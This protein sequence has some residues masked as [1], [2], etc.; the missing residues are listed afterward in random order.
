MSR[1]LSES[2]KRS[3]LLVLSAL[4]GTW[5]GVEDLLFLGEWCKL[6]DRKHVWGKRKYETVS[7]H[8]DD[9]GLLKKDYNYL[10]SLHHKLLSVLTNALNEFHSVNYSVRYWQLL[11]DPWLFSYISVLFDRWEGLR[12]AFEVYGPL[13]LLYIEEKKEI[14]APFSYEA[15]SGLAMSDEWNQILCQRIIG[16][17]FSHM[18]SFEKSENLTTEKKSYVAVKKKKSKKSIVNKICNKSLSAIDS[19][20]SRCS[21]KYDVVIYNANF[22]LLSLIGLNLT[23]GQ[24]PRSF[25]R[26]FNIEGHGDILKK[27]FNKS[28]RKKIH[29]DFEALSKFEAFI[30]D[31][32]VQ[33]IPIAVVEAYDSICE[34]VRRVPINVRVILTASG[35]WGNDL[36]KFWAAEKVNG[37]ASLVALEHGGSFPAYKEL[38]DFEESISDYKAT[39]FQPYH[40][41]HIQ[42]SPS[43]IIGR[44]NGIYKNYM[45]R[46]KQQYCMLVGSE[47][48]RW[49]LRTHFYPMAGQCLRSFEMTL[50]LHKH[51]DQN[52]KAMFKVKPYPNQGF[53]TEA[54][55]RDRLG[56]QH[57]IGVPNLHKA[58]SM[59]K[60]IICTYPETT[61]SEA[62][63][64]GIPALL[65]Y[66]FQ[67][68]ERHAIALNLLDILREAKIIFHDAQDAAEHIN[69][70]WVDPEIWWC[71]KQV[72][73]AREQFRKIALG[74]LDKT[75]K[76]QWKKFLADLEAG[77]NEN[78][79]TVKKV[80]KI[81]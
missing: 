28:I 70:I 2:A 74:G 60:L 9:R 59:S 46:K 79:L 30:K 25:T 31:D 29:F 6:Y 57:V 36:F 47:C 48:Q 66:P 5:G 81:K 76:K 58:F 14:I 37:N 64:S 34:H 61:F 67:L 75:W 54:R 33:A 26:E 53:N 23:L 73:Y 62:M 43:K 32:L 71:S 13:D 63:A 21:S 42:V 78:T 72:R 24:I 56:A 35:H 68:Y 65:I 4:E 50:K 27:P 1:P 20:L 16:A 39:W 52:V 3:R 80:A 11:L 22:N 40:E 7:F 77:K 69:S 49:V 41:K 8:W 44:F 10:E 19:L 38:F 12:I 17:A 45:T 51:L 18:C 55:Y 15:F